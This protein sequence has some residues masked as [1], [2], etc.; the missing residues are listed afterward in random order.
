MALIHNVIIRGMN[1]M[2]LQA[3]YISPS[4][5]SDFLTFCQCWS[6]LLHNHHHCEEHA[7]FPVIERACGLE[8]IADSNVDQHEVFMVGLHKFD[9]YVY[10]V[11]PTSF[12]GD[13]L[14]EILDLF[15][16]N[17]QM[18]LTD[19][20]LWIQSLSKYPQLDLGAVDDHHASY[21]RARS[22]KT[23]LMPILL[24]NHDV[25]YEDA[26]HRWWPAESRTTSEFFMRYMWSLWNRGAW[27]YS[28]CALSGKP[29]RL[30]ALLGGE[31]MTSIR[32]DHETG[33]IGP[34]VPGEGTTELKRPER[35]HTRSGSGTGSVEDHPD[36]DFSSSGTTV[37]PRSSIGRLVHKE[38]T[39][40][41]W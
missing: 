37:T 6:E 3:E 15:C 28:S 22:S 14:I 5:A 27:Q 32:N 7:Y 17:L 18:H 19:E 1:S 30:V 8:G 33:P 41:M 31:K 24:S 40:D 2:Y 23:R 10:K 38:K 13:K 25:T 11:A 35:A 12:S 20:I 21:I 26:I 39:Q 36:D 34:A 9:D 4:K 29:K 16:A